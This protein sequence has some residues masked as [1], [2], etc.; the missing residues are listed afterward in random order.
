M[1]NRN[2]VFAKNP[3]SG[4]Q[5]MINL[6]SKSRPPTWREMNPYITPEEE[7]VLFQELREMPPWRKFEIMDSLNRATKSLAMVILYYHY[8]TA[9]DAEIKRRFADLWLGEELAA[10][11]FGPFPEIYNRKEENQDKDQSSNP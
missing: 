2:G 4:Y 1:M 8:P 11:A 3:V 7:K 9:S 6:T 5:E 10:K